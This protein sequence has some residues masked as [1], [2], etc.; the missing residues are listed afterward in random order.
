MP[1]Y[2]PANE[3]AA[4]FRLERVDDEPLPVGLQYRHARCSLTRGHIRLSTE[5][6]LGSDGTISITLFGTMSGHR[7]LR[8]IFL[9]NEPYDLIDN[10][11][12]TFPGG[13]R[14]WGRVVRPHCV[15]RLR[16]DEIVLTPLRPEWARSGLGAIF[17]AHDWHFV[18]T[19]DVLFAAAAR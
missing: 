8:Q 4:F 17:G 9:E 10:R 3:P 14:K 2:D 12:L 6:V 1:L 11:H 13:W 15:V 19:D 16:L 5:R 18:R 7:E